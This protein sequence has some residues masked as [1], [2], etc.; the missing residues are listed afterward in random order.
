MEISVRQSAQP[1]GSAPIATSGLSGLARGGVPLW[2]PLP[3]LLTGVLG[4][5]LFGAVLPF[6]APQALLAPGFP[7]VL[8]LVH[9]VTLGWLTMT[10]MGASLQL[11]P[12]ILVSP[13]RATRLARAQY[14]VYVLGVALLIGGFWTMNIPLLITGGSLVVLAVAHYVVILGVTIARATTRPLTARYFAAAMVYLL[15][16]VSLGFTAALNFQFGFLGAGVERLL[17]AHITAGVVG[18]L[19]CTL[20]GVSYTLTRMFALVHDHADDLGRR[21][22]LLLNAGIVGL[23][24]GFGFG[25]TWLQA[26]GGL[27]LIAA[28]WLFAYDYRRMLRARK[29]KPLDVTQF[30]AIAAVGYLVVTITAGV[31]VALLGGGRQPVLVALGLAALVGWLGQSTLGYLYK[32]VPFLIWQSR[33]GPLVGRQKVPLM[34]D[35]IHQRAALLSFWLINGGLALALA[36]ALLNWAIPLQVAAAILGVGLVVVAANVIGVVVPRVPHPQP[37]LPVGERA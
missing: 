6:V 29:R 19:T 1:Q 37:S 16:V 23:A 2:L 5:A 4:A 7:H 25:W 21:V 15:I 30:H 24:A 27:S 28:V 26:V 10:I 32:I 18:W 13:L 22:F 12:V 34:R 11:A 20:I 8:A 3:F 14:P 33:Y 31:A 17:L 9:T 35:L 36:C